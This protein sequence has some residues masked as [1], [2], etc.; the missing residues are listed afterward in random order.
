LE[1]ISRLFDEYR[2]FYRQAPNRELARA[3]ILERL[4]NKDS[5]ILL[6]QYEDAAAGFAQLYPSFSSIGAAR[7][8]ILNDLYICQRSRRLGIAT[9]LLKAAT[10]HAKSTGATRLSLATAQTNAAARTLY[11]LNGWRRNFEFIHYSFTV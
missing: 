4:T 3:F 2:Q 11:E 1:A 10:D 7:T 9:R 6:A 8:W 5:V